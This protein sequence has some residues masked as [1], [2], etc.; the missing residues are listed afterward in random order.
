MMDICHYTLVQSHRTYNP[1]K[2]ANVNYR[3]WGITLCQCGLI[4][5]NRCATLVSDV[6]SR[7]SGAYGG[8]GVCGR[9][10]YLPLTFVVNLKLL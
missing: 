7:G 2:D 8:Q 4:L 6:D 9:S 1:K 3:L 10:L 5:D